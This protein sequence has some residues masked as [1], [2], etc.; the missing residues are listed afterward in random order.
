[1]EIDASRNLTFDW[2]G[3]GSHHEIHPWGAFKQSYRYFCFLTVMF[4]FMGKSKIEIK[5]SNIFLNLWHTASVVLTS[6]TQFWF[7][8]QSEGLSVLIFVNKKM[9]DGITK[10]DLVMWQVW[11]RFLAFA[12]WAAVLLLIKSCGK[13]IADVVGNMPGTD[14]KWSRTAAVKANYPSAQEGTIRNKRYVDA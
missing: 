1:M 2:G 10:T 12:M 13:T 5:F 8:F 9:F 4:S 6:L 11:L 7:D 14:R 3:I